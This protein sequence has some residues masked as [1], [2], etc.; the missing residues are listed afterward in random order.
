[1]LS[2]ERFSYTVCV[3][4]AFGA[5]LADGLILERPSLKLQSERFMRRLG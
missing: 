5:S 2:E 3:T 4:M 1:M